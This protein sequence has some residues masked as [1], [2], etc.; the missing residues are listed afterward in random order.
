MDFG[1]IFKT[2]KDPI[3]PLQQNGTVYKV[4][5]GDCD[6]VYIGETKRTAATRRKEHERDIRNNQEKSALSQHAKYTGHMIDWDTLNVLEY[7]HDFK[8]RRFLESYHICKERSCLNKKDCD[9]FSKIHGLLT[10][11]DSQ[12]T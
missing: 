10:A 12:K 4:K 1:N 3:P 5:C 11:L 8:K 2:P 9:N 6:G 7:E